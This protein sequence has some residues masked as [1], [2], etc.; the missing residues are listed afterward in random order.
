MLSS[1]A[2]AITQ[3]THAVDSTKPPEF[4]DLGNPF[5]VEHYQGTKLAHSANVKSKIGTVQL[6]TAITSHP[7]LPVNAL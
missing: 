7:V 2:T 6:L 5:L 1:I 3:Y 4:M